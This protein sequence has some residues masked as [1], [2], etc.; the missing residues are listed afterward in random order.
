MRES[1]MTNTD[2]VD[3]EITHAE[4]ILYLGIDTSTLYRLRITGKI[5]A[6]FHNLKDY[7]YMI[8]ELDRYISEHPELGARYADGTLMNAPPSTHLDI[9]T[10]STEPL[11]KEEEI[12]E[13]IEEARGY[14]PGHESEPVS[15]RRDWLD[16][17]VIR[18]DDTDWE[19]PVQATEVGHRIL[20]KREEMVVV[21]E[22]PDIHAPRDHGYPN[23]P[24]VNPEEWIMGVP[25]K[26]WEHSQVG[27]LLI[28]ENEY[29]PKKKKGKN[30]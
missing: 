7:G 1:S 23:A 3:E 6:V 19:K 10:P 18:C 22:K 5:K 21:P 27:D 2:Y 16:G 24:P 14:E 29:A 20:S 11:T 8:S 17:F 13:I 4:A 26:G 15:P 28:G 12:K 25:C 9:I 30:K